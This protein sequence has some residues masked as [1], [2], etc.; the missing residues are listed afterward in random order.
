MP[1]FLDLRN[2]LFADLALG[3][4]FVEALVNQIHT[5]VNKLLLDITE[6]QM[7]ADRMPAL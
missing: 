3:G 7:T 4:K 6:V 2:R 5:A 1:A